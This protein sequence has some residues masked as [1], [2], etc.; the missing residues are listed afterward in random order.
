MRYPTVML[1]S[2]CVLAATTTSA[3]ADP[4]LDCSRRALAN[5][6]ERA[7][8]RNREITFT[9]TCQG[10]IVIQLDGLTLRGVGNAV[11]DGGGHD[12]VTVAGASGVVLTGIEIR[13]GGNG[14]VGVNGA[15]LS[16]SDLNVHDNTGFGISLQTG[17]SAVL[18][19]VTIAGSGMNGLDLQTGSAAT[20]TGILTVTGSRVFGINV[21][22]SALT[23]S[24]ATVT[25]S[26]NALGIQ[27]ATGGN[28]FIN[29]RKSTIN[30]TDNLSTGLTIVSG[31]HMVS[32]GGTINA[33]GNRAVG[34]SINSKSGLD[35][36]AG[37][38]LTS[39]GNVTGVLI[40]H[41]SV[42]TVFNTTQFSG[43]PGNSTVNAR[44]NTGNGIR[45][46][47]GSLLQL[48]NQAEV[49]STQNGLMGLVAD[50]GAGLTLVNATLTGNTATDLV[51]T[52]GARA[53]LRTTT[54]GTF[55]CDPTVLVRGTSSVVCP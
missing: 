16:L 49:T 47:T 53:D 19:G 44:L 46:L 52:F 20:V 11:I 55:T 8:E 21:N 1:L 7:H 32:F 31:A 51:L 13:N 37:S 12:V 54:L 17:S 38:V 25:A 22:G 34:V 9:G 3:A 14:I 23:L 41:E 15:H 39:T 26:G 40:Q 29:D 5:A 24:M 45:V 2:S 43:A 50:N 35:L 42:M 28:A 10:P 27:I 6:V 18:E 4:V 33:T 36:D 30:V 48:T